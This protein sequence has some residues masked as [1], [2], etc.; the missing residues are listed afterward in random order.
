MMTREAWLASPDSPIMPTT[1]L[2]ASG[3]TARWN[4][5]RTAPPIS[6]SARAISSVSALV[7]PG[8]AAANDRCGAK[9]DHLSPS[10]SGLVMQKSWQA[11]LACSRNCSVVIANDSGDVPMTRNLRGISPA[12]ARWNRPG[13]SLRLARSPV[14][15]NRTMTWSS[16]RRLPEAGLAWG[17]GVSAGAAVMESSSLVSRGGAVGCYS[18]RGRGA[19]GEHEGAPSLYPARGDGLV[20]GKQPGERVTLVRAGDQPQQLIGSGQRGIRQGHP[21]LPLVRL[22]ERHQRLCDGEHRIARH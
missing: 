14:A 17:R 11:R 15:P 12:A 21:L 20:P 7:A 3:G 22:R 8:S 19:V 6:F 1:E 10:R 18:A 13:S 9:S 4:R 16:G 2:K 5:R